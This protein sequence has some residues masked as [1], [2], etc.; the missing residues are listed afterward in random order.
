MD[1]SHGS[2]TLD[3]SNALSTILLNSLCDIYDDKLSHSLS[4]YL[5]ILNI[6]IADFML[7][8]SIFFTIQASSIFFKSLIFS[9]IL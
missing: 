2:H 4:C 1:L 8:I 7:L 6:Y 5:N 3:M 9:F